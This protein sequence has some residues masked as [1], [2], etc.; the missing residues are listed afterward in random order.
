M[1]ALASIPGNAQFVYVANSGNPSGVSVY[2]MDP[3]S[4]N[5]TPVQGSPFAS[6]FDTNSVT[7]DPFGQALY[8]TNENSGNI[9]VYA[10]DPFLGGLTPLGTVAAGSA[11][12]PNSVK[13]HPS[14]SFLYV[15]NE[16]DGTIL[17][18]RV[19]G[20]GSLTP[21]TG[22]PFPTPR[23]PDSISIDP[24]GRF[25]YASSGDGAAPTDAAVLAYAINQT[26][27]ALTAVPG[28]PFP[29]GSDIDTVV[30]DPTGR[31]LYAGDFTGQQV[32]AFSING[33]GALTPVAGSPFAAGGSPDEV[34]VDPLGRFVYTAND[35]SIGPSGVGA[36]S[37]NQNTGV[38]TTITG[39]PFSAGNSPS[40]V[41]ADPTGHFLF[42]ANENSN[43]VSAFSIN[44][45]SG[46]LTPIGGSPFVAGSEPVKIAAAPINLFNQFFLSFFFE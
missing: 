24:S 42:A 5:L 4:G 22:S 45:G 30:V 20:L 15:A 43:N 18:Y 12:G 2:A 8:V 19:T 40:G 46:A 17:G 36:F 26:T 31:F 16:T 11:N 13:L 28:S 23:R 29:A 25:L 1:L 39:S 14:G 35:G 6:G 27:G 9:G 41:T 21:I 32:F 34:T 10:I 33:L 38:L 44:P 7:V 37:I 3:T